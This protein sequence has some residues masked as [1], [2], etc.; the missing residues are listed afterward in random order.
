M[1]YY[2]HHVPGRIRIKT[3]QLKYK[4]CRCHSARTILS[5]LP[6]VN[7]VKTNPTTGSLTLRYD[8]NIIKADTIIKHMREN[9]VVNQAIKTA[10]NKN[11][12][13]FESV[14]NDAGEKVGKVLFSWVVGKALEANGLSLLAAL[15]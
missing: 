15:I 13:N 7:E 14:I 5:G 2:I 11:G 12:P 10:G 9:G 3:P 8:N 4:S 1:D 6:G